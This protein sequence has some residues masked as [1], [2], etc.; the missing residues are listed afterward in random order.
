[1]TSVT[2]YESD[3]RSAV[4]IDT[5]KGKVTQIQWKCAEIVGV[6]A[7]AKVLCT[8]TKL[9]TVINNSA[10]VSNTLHSIALG[11]LL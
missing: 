10:N 6:N 4:Y 7:N 5:S 9:Q 2:G 1:M 8:F 11:V 3:P